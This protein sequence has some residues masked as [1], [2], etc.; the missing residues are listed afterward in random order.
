MTTLGAHKLDDR[1]VLRNKYI[2]STWF[3][4]EE[5]SWVTS[6][7]VQWLRLH[8]SYAG[9]AGLIPDGETKIPYVMWP[10]KKIKRGGW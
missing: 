4:R 7:A 2:V 9:S 5:G 8:S 1:L 10:K 3:K 6:L